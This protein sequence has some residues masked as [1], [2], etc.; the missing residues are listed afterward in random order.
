M[1]QNK[2]LKEIKTRFNEEQKQIH[3]SD[4]SVENFNLIFK[5]LNFFCYLIP[6]VLEIDV[7]LPNFFFF[8]SI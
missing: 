2:K 8:I 7:S 5:V 4:F 3:H 6:I 1:V